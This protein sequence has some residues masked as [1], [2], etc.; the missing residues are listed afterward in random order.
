MFA[1]TEKWFGGI[2]GEG[3]DLTV[4]NACNQGPITGTKS[5][6]VGGIVGSLKN[7]TVQNALRTGTVKRETWGGHE[8]EAVGTIVGEADDSQIRRVV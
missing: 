2:V 4:E 3:K 6:L 5:N 1:T 7:S 8:Q